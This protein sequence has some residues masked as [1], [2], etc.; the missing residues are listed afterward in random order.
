MA[1]LPPPPGTAYIQSSVPCLTAFN[2]P[3][4]CSRTLLLVGINGV[5]M[6]GLRITR[7]FIVLPLWVAIFRSMAKVATIDQVICTHVC[8]QFFSGTP[9]RPVIIEH[10]RVT[11][12][13]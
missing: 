11:Q 2:A 4:L 9:R 6:R 3:S 8:A 12:P 13:G 10:H 1:T 5:P 7:N